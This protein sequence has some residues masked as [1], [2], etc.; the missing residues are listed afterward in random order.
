M[1]LIKAWEIVNKLE[2]SK[3]WWLC[4]V[5]A[6]NLKILKIKILLKLIK[7]Y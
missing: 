4:F 5:G 3:N 7:E 6:G 1:N 2:S